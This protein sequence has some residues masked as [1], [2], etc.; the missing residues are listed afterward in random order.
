MTD[1]GRCMGALPPP[2]G[3]TWLDCHACWCV[4]HLSQGVM[5]LSATWPSSCSQHAREAAVP[6]ATAAAPRTCRA[7]FAR[8]CVSSK[9][10]R[11][12]ADWCAAFL[13]AGGSLEN[14]EGPDPLAAFAI[15]DG[16]DLATAGPP[17]PGAPQSAVEVQCVRDGSFFDLSPQQAQLN[18]YEGECSVRPPCHARVASLFLGTPV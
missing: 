2:R 16:K 5:G 14:F 12:I 7:A 15:V 9:I 11:R 3:G 10:G 13:P 18:V 1:S 4:C 17:V 8:A 6:P